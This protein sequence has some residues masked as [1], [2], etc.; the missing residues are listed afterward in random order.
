MTLSI[1][2]PDEAEARLRKRAAAAGQ[3]VG[4]FVSNLVAHFAGPPTPIEELSGPTY[5]Q[6]LDS[7]MSDDELGDLIERTKHEMRAERR[8]ANP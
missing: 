2:I 8:R 7:G 6:F 4:T 1:S 3:D 5:Q